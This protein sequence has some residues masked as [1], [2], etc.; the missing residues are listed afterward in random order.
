MRPGSPSD[1]TVPSLRAQFMIREIDATG[2]VDV[3]ARELCRAVGMDLAQL[4]DPVSMIPLRQIGN[5]YEEAA[6]R[7]GDDD[8][9]LHVGERSGPAI[10][11]VV[12]YA[13][14]SRPTLAKA[15]DDLRP[16]IATLYPEAELTL[17]VDGNVACFRYRLF[18]AREADSQRHRCESLLAGLVGLVHRAIGR[19][20]PLLGV[21]FQHGKPR[22][23]GEHQRIFRGPLQF[24]W[25]S[26][27]L[28]FSA[29]WLSVPLTT[30]DPNLCAVLDRHLNDL[31]SRMPT[32]PTA[33]RFTHDV[34]RRLAQ[35]F[36]S[37]TVSLPL[38]AKSL[39]VSERTL[40]RRLHEEGTSLHE[41][42]EGVR[43][44]LSL[45]LLR[46]SDLS[47]AEVAQRLGYAS[48]A[49]FSRA[50]RRWKGVSPA[51][52]RRA[53]RPVRPVSTA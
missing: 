14:I 46:D 1:V 11:D 37:G 31:L 28:A 25:H 4:E 38:L 51:A 53:T 8:L 3:P 30:A 7:T 5:V 39:G 16:L 41:L 29:H 50:F 9:G 24:D 19:A 20:E 10:V 27:E 44:E 32:A 22:N 15:Y 33:R 12:D 2:V 43:S 48:L 36:R 13:F 18:D 40:Q 26:Y 21:S 52:H 34:R 45:S 23:V 6:R 49:A 42:M 17:S 35:V 47:V